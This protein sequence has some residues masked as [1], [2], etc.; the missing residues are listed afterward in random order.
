M[1]SFI[2]TFVDA[3]DSVMRKLGGQRLCEHCRQWAKKPYQKGGL[4]F[5]DHIHAS[6]FYK[7]QQEQMR[8]ALEQQKTTGRATRDQ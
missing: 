7:R 6:I 2:A 4:Y 5:C 1:A 3:A 8:Q